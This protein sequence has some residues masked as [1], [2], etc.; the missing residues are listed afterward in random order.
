[1]NVLINL[2]D[3]KEFIIVTINNKDYQIKLAGTIN[4][5]YFCGKD[6]C[7]VLGYSNIQKVLNDYVDSIYKKDLKTL[8]TVNPLQGWTF[9]G[10]NNISYNEDKV[11]YINE[12]GLYS[13]VIHSKTPFAKF[14][15]KLIYEVILPSF[16]KHRSYYIKQQLAIKDD[17][18]NEIIEKLTIKDKEIENK[19]KLLEDVYKTKNKVKKIEL[20]TLR[21][22]KF[23]NNIKIKEL[24]LEWIY[25]ATT[26]QYVKKRLFKIGST[27]RLMSRIDPY[28]SRSKE[29]DY[30]Y[31]WAV[32]CYN[33]KELDQHIQKLLATFKYD[34]SNDKSLTLLNKQ[35]MYQGIKFTD[36]VVIVTFIIE[37]YDKSI[38][39][40]NTF[41]K[42][43]LDTSIKEDIIIP[44]R[45]NLKQLTFKIGEHTEVIDLEKEEEVIIREELTVLLESL[46]DRRKNKD[47]EIIVMK[48]NNIVDH[49]ASNAMLDRTSLWNR[50]KTVFIERKINL[51]S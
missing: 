5:P 22:K 9:L 34:K 44:E 14:F 36:L 51:Q 47:E 2:K 3:C 25:I 46:S 35:K 11:I 28:N 43:K 24:K 26:D 18:L 29:D 37:N 13:L 12:P 32:K 45:L 4:D 23:M 38:D 1:M 10:S 50:V 42:N 41:I 15:Q 17:Q 30:Y 7:E 27:E 6:V 31:V 19:N 33:C 49:L 16:R 8:I 48:N 40:I 20:K 39:F 21:I